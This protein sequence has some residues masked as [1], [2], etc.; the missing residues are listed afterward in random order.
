[1][2]ARLKLLLEAVRGGSAR[3][4]LIDWLAMLAVLGMLASR[5]S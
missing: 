1:V 2:S 5:W 4:S 3:L